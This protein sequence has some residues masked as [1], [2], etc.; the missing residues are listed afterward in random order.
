VILQTNIGGGGSGSFLSCPELPSVS[1]RR[2]DSNLL[3]VI[4]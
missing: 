4:V 2:K 1:T 3:V